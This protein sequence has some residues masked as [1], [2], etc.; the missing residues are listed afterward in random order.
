M[1]ATWWHPQHNACWV[2]CTGTAGFFSKMKISHKVVLSALQGGS[3][4]QTGPGQTRQDWPAGGKRE[5]RALPVTAGRAARQWPHCRTFVTITAS[6]R[7]WEELTRNNPVQMRS[8]QEWPQSPLTVLKWLFISSVIWSSWNLQISLYHFTGELWFSI[9]GRDISPFAINSWLMQAQ[10]CKG[11][12]G[13]DLM[14]GLRKHF[15]PTC[16][17]RTDSCA[18]RAYLCYGIFWKY[19]CYDR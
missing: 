9:F 8:T 18:A 19:Y 14:K 4:A 6:E 10:R 5:V 12:T 7:R 1:Q 16:Q 17:L 15:K 11:N 3:K 2:C 13:S